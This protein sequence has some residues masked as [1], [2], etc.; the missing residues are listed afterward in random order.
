MRYCRYLKPDACNLSVK[1]THERCECYV[2]VLRSGPEMVC[3]PHEGWGAA[4]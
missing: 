2:R 3:T 4:A 1:Y